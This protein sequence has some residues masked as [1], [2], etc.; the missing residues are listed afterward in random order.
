MVH[1][2]VEVGCDGVCWV[3]WYTRNGDD[4]T[5]PT[6]CVVLDHLTTSSSPGGLS[7]MSPRQAWH[8]GSKVSTHAGTKLLWHS[9]PKN[10]KVRQTLMV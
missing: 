5:F 4:G 1:E 6:I 9:M 8:E 7:M 3:P 2:Q 10:P